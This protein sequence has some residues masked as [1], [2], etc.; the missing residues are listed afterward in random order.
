MDVRANE[1]FI[2][3]VYDP[4]LYGFNTA[5]WKELNGS[6]VLSANKIRVNSVAIVSR[7]QYLRGDFTFKLN[8]PADP[9]G[10]H[11]VWGLKLP[12]AS[13]DKN[14]V[15]FEIIGGVFQAVVID[16]NGNQNTY[17]ITWDSANWTAHDILYRIVW[18][19]G[20]V[21]FYISGIQVALF[22]DR[23]QQPGSQ[24]LS[25][26]VES[27]ENDNMD[28][29]YVAMSYVEKTFVPIWE[30]LS[31][32]ATNERT[33]ESAKDTLSISE[34][35][36]MTGQLGGINV[37]DQLNISEFTDV[38]VGGKRVINTNDQ[39]SISESVTVVKT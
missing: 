27:D 6:G 33:I 18:I 29:S 19:K 36:T 8:I 10:P 32:A 26:W 17:T 34:S 11:R 14:A 7:H 15:Y 4:A 5:Y 30:S 28:L 1:D 22:D 13:A 9:A 23:N 12:N 16:A 20:R 24:T 21:I 25:A 39:L 3:F 31:T 2:H 35:V 38:L 37:N